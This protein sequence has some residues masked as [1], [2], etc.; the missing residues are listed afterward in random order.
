MSNM[1]KK[2]KLTQS[3]INW[4]S[5][6]LEKTPTNPYK[7]RNYLKKFLHIKHKERSC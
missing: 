1:N 3:N 6:I 7:H 5:P 2:E 4:E